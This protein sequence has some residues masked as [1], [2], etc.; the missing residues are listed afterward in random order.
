M[1][2]LSCSTQEQKIFSLQRQLMVEEV[3]LYFDLRRKYL[4][5]PR[6]GHQTRGRG[7]RLTEKHIKPRKERQKCVCCCCLV[8]KSCPTYCNPMN[9]S[10]PGSSVH[11]TFQAEILEWVVIS[12]SRG[13]P[14]PRDW[15]C[16]S[17]GSCIGRWTLY[18][19][20]HQGSPQKYVKMGKNKQ[21]LVAKVFPR[22]IYCRVND[23]YFSFGVRDFC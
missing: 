8:G 2:I 12:F 9:C 18:P 22:K 14:W 3:K 1:E 10:L 4:C 11:G 19:L 5:V 6:L 16:I 21:E 15:T 7:K 13:S 20:N 17:C 23:I